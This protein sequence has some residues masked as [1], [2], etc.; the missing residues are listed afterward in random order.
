MISALA[1]AIQTLGPDDPEAAARWENAATRAVQFISRELHESGGWRLWRGWRESR[2]AAPGFA[3]DYAFL[4]QGLLDLYEA[5]GAIHWLQWADR[6]QETMDAAFWD[7]NAGGYFSSAAGDPHLLVRMKED[8]DGAEPA[9][10]SVTALNLL[11]LD[12]ML[13]GHGVRA[14]RARETLAAFRAQLDRA[15]QGLPQML[16][17]SDF[18]IGPVRQIVIAGERNSPEARALLRAV[19]GRL[20]AP[21]VILWADDGEGQAWLAGRQP[22]IAGVKP[23]DGRASVSVCRDNTCGLP[24]TDPEELARQ[25]A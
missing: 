21:R 24:V 3:E 2:G 16:V 8:Y 20:E 18:A 9:A 6:L 1:R 22:W 12:G 11:R 4:I 13:G 19:H 5:T 15:P 10:N 7:A 25:L 14:D 23:V 17:A